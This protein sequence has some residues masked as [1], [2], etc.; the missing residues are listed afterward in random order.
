MCDAWVHGRG[1][2]WFS[3]LDW[4]QH[5]LGLVWLGFGSLLILLVPGLEGV[6]CRIALLVTV[7]DRVDVIVRC[8]VLSGLIMVGGTEALVA[9]F[10]ELLF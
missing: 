1:H 6:N 10:I 5:G 3:S 4:L 2:G 7:V 9:A 8:V